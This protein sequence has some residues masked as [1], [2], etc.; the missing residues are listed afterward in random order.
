MNVIHP[1]ADDAIKLAVR[2]PQL[3]NA[4][5][6]LSDG[7]QGLSLMASGIEQIPRRHRR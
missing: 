7:A 1:G 2:A 5:Q 6:C 4:T 3:E